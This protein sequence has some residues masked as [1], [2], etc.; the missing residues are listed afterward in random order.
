M[1]AVPTPVYTGLHWVGRRRR[2]WTG[3][4]DCGLGTV[5][6]GPRWRLPNGKIAAMVLVTPATEV[7][8]GTV[9]GSS[10]NVGRER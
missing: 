2:V 8:V 9:T 6:A 3:R 4:Y 1:P 10:A 7:V 5:G